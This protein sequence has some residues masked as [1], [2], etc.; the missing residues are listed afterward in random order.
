[1][2]FVDAVAAQPLWVKYWLY[3]LSFGGFALPVILLAWRE[4]RKPALVTLGGIL[5]SA[6]PVLWIYSQL[7]Y[8]K[9][10]GLGHL[11][12]WTP[13]V[14]YLFAEIKS[15]RLPPWPR[16]IM[17]VAAVTL[18]VSLAFDLTDTVRYVLGERTPLPGSI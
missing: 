1:M 18:A 8:V 16:R 2:S 5:L 17:V 14:L 11:I 3:W 9:L 7:G 4:T 13:G 12:F 15:V 10:L 6:F